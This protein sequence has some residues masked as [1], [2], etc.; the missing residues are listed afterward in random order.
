MIGGGGAPVGGPVVAVV[1]RGKG[2]T[3]RPEITQ[4]HQSVGA[5]GD[6]APVD[7]AGWVELND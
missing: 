4:S 1:R 5:S 7:S 3:E 2:G 6:S